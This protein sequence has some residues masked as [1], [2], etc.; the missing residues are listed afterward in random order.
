MSFQRDCTERIG[1]VA[2]VGESSYG[3]NCR[4]ALP[5]FLLKRGRADRSARDVAE[6]V[7]GYLVI[8]RD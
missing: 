7:V 1:E 8:V 3:L 2:G 4:S 5:N 6:S